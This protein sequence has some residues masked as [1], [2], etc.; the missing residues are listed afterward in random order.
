MTSKIPVRDRDGTVTGILGV[1][2]DITTTKRLETE[3]QSLYESFPD[4]YLVIRSDGQILDCNP[5]AERLLRGEREEIL[6]RSVL[7][8]SPEVQ[9]N[10]RPSAEHMVE[11]IRAVEETGRGRFE[12]LHQRLNG[13]SFQ[14]DVQLSRT[15]RGGEKVYLGSIR[16]VSERRRLEANLR[17]SNEESGAV[18]ALDLP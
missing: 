16:D 10:E 9:W 13:E 11:Q 3:L 2:T 7:D 15:E 8:I 6:G 14:C 4:A 5:A 12:W 18:R 1:C 17:R